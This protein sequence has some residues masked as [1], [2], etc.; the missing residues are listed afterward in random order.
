MIGLLLAPGRWVAD[1][2]WFALASRV[3]P[4]VDDN[5]ADVGE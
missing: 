1:R 3:L 4:A 5:L 2:V